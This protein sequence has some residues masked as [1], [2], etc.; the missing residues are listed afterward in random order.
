MRRLVIGVAAGLLLCPLTIASSSPAC[1]ST[2]IRERT[3]SRLVVRPSLT[4]S[5]GLITVKQGGGNV[6]VRAKQLE[7]SVKVTSVTWTEE[8]LPTRLW[9]G[10]GVLGPWWSGSNR[11]APVE[12]MTPGTQWV[13]GVHSADGHVGYALAVSRNAVL[14]PVQL[15]ASDDVDGC[16]PKVVNPDVLRRT[17]QRR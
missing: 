14:I 1:A 4:W 8:A 13:V 12:R 11:P 15:R 10:E 5:V 6:R 7:T 17:A 9:V 2:R 3:L 16:D